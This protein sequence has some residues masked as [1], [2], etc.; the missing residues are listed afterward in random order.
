LIDIRPPIFANDDYVI[1]KFRSSYLGSNSYVI[2]IP[3]FLYVVDTGYNDEKLIEYL[4][5]NDKPLDAVFLT[6]AHFDHAGTARAIAEKFH[7]P[8][9]VI[10][11]DRGTLRQNNFLLKALGQR[12]DF[13]TPD[14]Q[15]VDGGFQFKEFQFH[16]CPGHTPGSALLTFRDLTFTGDSVYS[17]CI[18]L[19]SL[20]GENEIALRNSLLSYKELLK[21]STAIF[22]GHGSFT[23]GERLFQENSQLNKF[24]SEMN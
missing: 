3:E 12:P 20:P 4:Q 19:V 11:E 17:D 22:P 24:L 5:E 14:C 23:N 9:F 10:K 2:E 8:V 18:S 6:H 13:R 15:F 7:A 1:H 16:G 21:G